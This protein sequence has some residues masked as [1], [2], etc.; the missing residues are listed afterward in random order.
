VKALAAQYARLRFGPAANAG[1][2]ASLERDVR[3]L[4]V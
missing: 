2:V 4:A 3:R 1:D